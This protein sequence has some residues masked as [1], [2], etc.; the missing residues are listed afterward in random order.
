MPC[1]VN[2]KWSI[3]FVSWAVNACFEAQN[4]HGILKAS[5]GSCVALLKETAEWFPMWTPQ[6]ALQTQTR[7]RF[8]FHSTS[9]SAPLMP[10]WGSEFTSFSFFTHIPTDIVGW[11]SSF[12]SANMS[13]KPPLAGTMGTISKFI[14]CNIQRS[15]E[16]A[17]CSNEI[18]LQFVTLKNQLIIPF[19]HFS[20]EEKIWSMQQIGLCSTWDQPALSFWPASG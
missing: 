1:L 2:K 19:V 9:S 5:T 18:Q 4:V 11:A 3:L 7:H 10:S 8:P 16:L 14:D 20:R 17:C 12:H 6:T 15:I 13:I